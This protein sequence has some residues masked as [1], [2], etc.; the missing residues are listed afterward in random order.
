MRIPA[1]KRAHLLYGVGLAAVSAVVCAVAR[2]HGVG[3]G[4]V[5][6]SI[7]FGFGL[8]VY[9]RVRGEGTASLA[10]G[11]ASAAA[12]VVLGLCLAALGV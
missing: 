5:V 11:A 2:S 6:C 12:G 4:V 10:D 9:Q 3:Y 8:E 1:D 7:V